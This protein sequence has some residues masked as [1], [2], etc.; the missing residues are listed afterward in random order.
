M[1][2]YDLL[3]IVDATFSMDNYLTSLHTSLPQIISRSALTGCFSRI[4]LLAYRDYRIREGLIEWSGWLQPDVK[5]VKQPDLVEMAKRLRQGEVGDVPEAVKTALAEAYLKMRSDAKTIVLLYTDA[6]PHSPTKL[7]HPNAVSERVALRYDEHYGDIG[8]LFINWVTACKTIR[9]LAQVFAVVNCNPTTATYYN[10]LCAITQVQRG[11]GSP[12]VGGDANQ[13]PLSARLALYISTSDIE[14]AQTED[15]IEATD[16]FPRSSVNS[17]THP[18]VDNITPAILT[19]N[20]LKEHLPKRPFKMQSLAERWSTDV[21]YKLMAVRYLLSVIKEDVVNLTVNPVF[22]SLWRTM[23]RDRTY[24][25]RDEL[26]NLFSQNVGRIEDL[27]DKYAMKVWLDES[28]DFTSEIMR[29]INSVP[30]NDRFPCVF[31]DPTLNFSSSEFNENGERA[32]PCFT[33]MELLEVGRS[34]KAYAL[35]RLSR[36]LS[37]LTIVNSANEMPEHIIATTVE[38]VPKIPLALAQ[39]EY[40]REFWKILFRCIVPGTRISDRSATLVAALSLRI[41]IKPLIDAAKC[42]MLVFK[43]Q[44]NDLSIPENWSI[45]C[46]GLLLD[47]DS[48]S[49]DQAEHSTRLLRPEDQRLFE[50]AVALK[51]LQFNLDMPL[52][53]VMSWTPNRDIAPIGPL[54]TCRTCNYPRSQRES[55]IHR[56]VLRDTDPTC[57]ATWVECSD[58]NCRARY[59]VYGVEALN[60]RPK[61]YYCRE[62][63]HKKTDFYPPVVECIQCSSRTIWP[64]S[65]QP[66]GWSEAEFICPLCTSG[67][68]PKTIEVQLTARKIGEE[69]PLSTW[70]HPD[71]APFSEYSLFGTVSSI[72]TD[73]FVSRI[74]LF[75]PREAP[76]VYQGKPILNTA[77]LIAS[78][79]SMTVHRKTWGVKCSLCFSD[80]RPG[81]LGAACGRRSCLQRICTSCLSGWYGIN[82]P[83]KIINTAALACPFCRRYPTAR[84]LA[85]AVMG[86]AGLAGLANAVRDQGVWIY[87]WCSDCS[88]AKQ[89]IE[90][91]CA[92]GAPHEITD[93]V[94]EE[95]SDERERQ[96]LHQERVEEARIAKILQKIKPCPGCGVLTEKIAGCGHITCPTEGCEVHWCYFCGKAFDEGRIHGHMCDVHGGIFGEDDLD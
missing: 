13:R 53:A 61:C 93:W 79:Q 49:R 26:F 77:S 2:S 7:S 40:G 30:G 14:K 78:L 71:T 41:G 72:G 11:T 6:P 82:A 34:C 47:A 3:I 39:G 12:A 68:Y 10:Y 27:D 52:T 29:I 58:P 31:L 17:H 92:G 42:Q 43:D 57:P 25:R 33:R 74:T 65:Y 16:Y 69:N 36:V 37:R 59:I 8:H 56:A 51:V 86:I 96:R 48:I 81:I 66:S 38:Q 35:R 5:G 70:L 46:L 63:C 32:I 50:H 80:F 44:W 83:G 28:Y 62:R 4:G 22:G 89:Y 55:W 95:C 24:E 73:Q 87:A 15:D 76:L 94:C 60:I 45:G 20:L 23:C 21:E 18:C 1:E 84:T 64:A 88:T 90:R 75:P 9:S 91:S 19:A 85:K 67:R 54:A